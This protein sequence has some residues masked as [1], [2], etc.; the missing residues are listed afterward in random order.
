[1]S[2]SYVVHYEQLALGA[3]ITMLVRQGIPGTFLIQVYDGE[4]L[5]GQDTGAFDYL[6]TSTHPGTIPFS[7]EPTGTS[8]TF[9]LYNTSPLTSALSNPFSGVGSAHAQGAGYVDSFVAPF[10][11][12]TEPV[13][14]SLPTPGCDLVD[15][16]GAVVGRFIASTNAY[17]APS[18]SALTYPVITI[19]QGTTL[20]VFGQDATHAYYKVQL[21]CTPLWVPVDTMTPNFNYPWFG[22]PLPTNVVD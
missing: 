20:W 5:L 21:G 2:G 14:P 1:M 8:V 15:L 16:T 9:Y 17:Y 19:D 7:T 4:T 18:E 3:R 22:W 6:I 10:S 11:P 12:C 13:L